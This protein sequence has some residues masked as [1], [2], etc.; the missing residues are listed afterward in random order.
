MVYLF[1]AS[2]A[3]IIAG[4]WLTFGIGPALIVAGGAGVWFSL[5][6]DGNR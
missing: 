4:V 3:A 1:A 2:A 5:S 6:W